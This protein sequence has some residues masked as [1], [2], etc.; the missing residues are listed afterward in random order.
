[1]TRSQTNNITQ[2][3]LPPWL[4]IIEFSKDLSYSSCTSI[5]GQILFPTQCHISRFSRGE[6]PTEIRSPQQFKSL[7]EAKSLSKSHTPVSTEQLKSH[8]HRDIVVAYEG[9][10]MKEAVPTVIPARCCI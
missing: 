4:W 8:C 3:E 6:S 2:N 10:E 5:S 1:M 7:N 9:T